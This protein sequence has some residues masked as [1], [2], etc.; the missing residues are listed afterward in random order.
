[1]EKQGSLVLQRFTARAIKPLLPLSWDPNLFRD[2]L[3]ELG[4]D[5][6]LK[7]RPAEPTEVLPSLEPPK[8]GPP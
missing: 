8:T 2:V 7:P 3:A 6:P 5:Q 4:T 1:M